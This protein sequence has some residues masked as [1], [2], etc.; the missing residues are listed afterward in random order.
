MEKGW[1]WNWEKKGFKNKANV[2][3]WKQYMDLHDKF[4]PKFIWIRGHAGHAEN[5][6]CDY[7]A[8]NAA[9]G[10]DLRIDAGYEKQKG[11][12]SFS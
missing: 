7:L 9:S 3:L 4:N 11:L 6:R 8:V 2:D 1:V 10:R 5:E 12:E